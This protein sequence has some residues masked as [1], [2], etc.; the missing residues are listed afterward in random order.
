[1]GRM[2]DTDTQPHPGSSGTPAL[3]ADDAEPFLAGRGVDGT[4]TT[5]AALEATL[6]R[7]SGR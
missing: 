6:E 2:T 1:M 4:E 7:G 3:P 5:L